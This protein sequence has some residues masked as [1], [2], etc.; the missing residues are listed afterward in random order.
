MDRHNVEFGAYNMKSHNIWYHRSWVD[1]YL[2]KTNVN[3]EKDPL[4]R[5][6][7]TVKRLSSKLDQF[8][9]G[10]GALL[11]VMIRLYDKKTHKRKDIWTDV[12]DL[13]SHM[14]LWMNEFITNEVQVWG[15]EKPYEDHTN[16]LKRK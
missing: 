4:W 15:N 11:Y 16:W 2:W 3:L 1:N 9:D 5:G 7:F 10:S 13:Q 6:R 12:L 14:F 8:E